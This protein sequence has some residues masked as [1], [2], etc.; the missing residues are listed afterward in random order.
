[1][2][3]SVCVKSEET[4]GSACS[5][6]RDRYGAGLNTNAAV[7]TVRLLMSPDNY[8]RLVHELGWTTMCRHRVGVIDVVH[9]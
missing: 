7:D 6:T 4:G 3:I 5:P 8:Y 1:M 2:P 9:C